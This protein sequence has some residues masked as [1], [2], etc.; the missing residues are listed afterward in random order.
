MFR[1]FALVIP[2][3][4]LGI[5]HH[6][7]EGEEEEIGDEVKEVDSEDSDQQEEGVDQEELPKESEC[8]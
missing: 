1:L 8:G 6:K 5:D 4:Q 7:D 3:N 2:L